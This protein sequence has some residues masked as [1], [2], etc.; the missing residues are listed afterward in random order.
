MKRP[1]VLFT[2]HSPAI[3]GAEVVLLE[4]LEQGAGASAF[5][6]QPGPLSE[7]LAA[8]GVRVTASRWGGRLGAVKRDR[9]LLRA[10]PLVWPIA[11]LVVELARL[12]PRY[13]IVYA[14]SQKA[15]ILSAI[16]TAVSRRPLIWH[17]HDIPD[18]N[19]FGAAQLKL[20]VGLANR[21][22][23]RVV[24]PSRA[25]ADGFIAAGGRADIV[26]IVP[27]GVTMAETGDV[28]PGRRLGPLS[29]CG[30]GR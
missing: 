30:R 2:S 23:A 15:F 5:V 25:V 29:A 14:N 13:D 19:H 12:A 11:A 21:R 16:A 24:V 9:S 1:N 27:N 10:L 4:L 20:Q 7:A 28:S 8:R 17:L 26:R 18:R 22:A 6:F 3:S